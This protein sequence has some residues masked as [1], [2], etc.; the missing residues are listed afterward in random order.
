MLTICKNFNLIPYLSNLKKLF[1]WSMKKTLHICKFTE[2]LWYKVSRI[3]LDKMYLSTFIDP[4]ILIQS[5]CKVNLLC[6]RFLVETSEKK[7][8][9]I[10]TILKETIDI[11]QI[12]GCPHQSQQWISDICLH[13]WL[14]FRLIIFQVGKSLFIL[15]KYEFMLELETMI[16]RLIHVYVG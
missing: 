14:D 1:L 11:F 5:I 3:F 10:G 8:S 12:I 16:F 7:N 4:S 13:R 15:T 2:V 6:K 9:S